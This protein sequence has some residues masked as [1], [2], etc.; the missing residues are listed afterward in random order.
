MSLVRLFLA[1]LVS[2]GGGMG[3]ERFNAKANTCREVNLELAKRGLGEFQIDP[4]TGNI[5]FMEK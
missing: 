4:K 2:F 3:F 1:V 5:V